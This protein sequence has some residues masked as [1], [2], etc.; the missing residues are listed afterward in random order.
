M[1]L[2]MKQAMSMLGEH[3]GGQYHRLLLAS[4]T[5]PP[6]R[7]RRLVVAIG[8]RMK[9]TGLGARIVKVVDA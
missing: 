1:A 8:G 6:K 9:R 2:T 3:V 7:R 4:L 5:T